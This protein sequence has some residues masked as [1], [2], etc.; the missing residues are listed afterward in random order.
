MVRAI[1]PRGPETDFLLFY[2]SSFTL[3]GFRV[4][5]RMLVDGKERRSRAQALTGAA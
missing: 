1:S 3:C 5:H 2:T 4:G